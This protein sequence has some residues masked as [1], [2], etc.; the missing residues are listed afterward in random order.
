MF[1]FLHPNQHFSSFT[2]LPVPSPHPPLFL[3]CSSDMNR[4]PMDIS[5]PW[6]QITVRLGTSFLKSTFLL[7][8]KMNSF[9]RKNSKDLVVNALLL[10]MTRELVF[11]D[12]CMFFLNSVFIMFWTEDCWPGLCCR[13]KVLLQS[14]PMYMQ[15]WLPSSIQNSRKLEN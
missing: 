10:F 9:S 1:L 11:F 4:P 5:W 2:F 8:T 14:L 6:Y 3:S 15:P 13:H 7:I 12:F